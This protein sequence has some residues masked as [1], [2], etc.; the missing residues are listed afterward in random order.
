MKQRSGREVGTLRMVPKDLLRDL[1]TIYIGTRHI[2]W[3]K[4]KG[5][6]PFRV[7]VQTSR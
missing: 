3:V 7:R 5:A 1:W 4:W 6:I 2:G